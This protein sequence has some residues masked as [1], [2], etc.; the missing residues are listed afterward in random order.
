[1]RKL[2]SLQQ[3]REVFGL[4]R[5]DARLHIM[6]VTV[7]ATWASETCI[8]LPSLV[9]TNRRSGT[10]RTSDSTLYRA[11]VWK[12]RKTRGIKALHCTAFH[13]FCSD[14]HQLVSL[15]STLLQR[16]DGI[17][18]A[19]LWE[20]MIRWCRDVRSIKSASSSFHYTHTHI[21]VRWML[22]LRSSLLAHEKNKRRCS[23]GKPATYSGWHCTQMCS[24]ISSLTSLSF[25]DGF[26]TLHTIH[27][28]GIFGTAIS[29]LFRSTAMPICE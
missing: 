11:L 10:H 1:M 13:L 27:C 17:Q 22:G 8:R 2:T 6:C 29:S 26:K 14:L 12:T 18:E 16:A 20:R 24:T 4:T 5:N 28:S 19:N 7:R 25:F 3:K 15:V 23:N 9:W 21:I